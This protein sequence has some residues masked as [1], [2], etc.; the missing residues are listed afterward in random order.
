MLKKL[1]KPNKR[2]IITFIFILF[3]ITSMGVSS[4][5]DRSP[6]PNTELNPTTS[7]IT[8]GGELNFD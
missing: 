6:L 3:F 2:T 8:L 5:R 7:R 4:V 1:Q